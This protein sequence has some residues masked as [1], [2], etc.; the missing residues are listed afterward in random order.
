[1]VE[2]NESAPSFCLANQDNEQVCLSDFK[3]KWI[4]LYFY[5]K[6]NTPACTLEAKHFSDVVDEFALYNAAVIGVSPD[7][8]DSHCK[9]KDKHGLSIQLLSDPDHTTL[10]DYGVWKPKKM[11]GKEFL[12]V[13][14]STFLINP[15]G[16]IVYSWPKVKVMGHIDEV[17]NKFKE[18]QK[19]E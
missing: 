4:V 14:R 18:L 1:M 19:K 5:P 10:K 2:I 6:D 16:T 8:V 9:F 13:I 3:G 17:M 7:S 11:Y 12:G 15:K